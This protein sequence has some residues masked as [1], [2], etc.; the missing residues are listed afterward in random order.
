MSHMTRFKAQITK[1][2]IRQ[3]KIQTLLKKNAELH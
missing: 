2:I 3:F 1:S